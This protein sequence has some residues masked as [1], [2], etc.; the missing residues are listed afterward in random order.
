MTALRIRRASVNCSAIAASTSTVPLGA[1][2]RRAASRYQRRPSSSR[3]SNVGQIPWPRSRV[4]EARRTE[5]GGLGERT[6]ERGAGRVVGEHA[7]EEERQVPEAAEDTGSLGRRD[8][9]EHPRQ[10]HRVEL[11]EPAPAPT[12]TCRHPGAPAH[13]VGVR[14]Q[15]LDEEEAPQ[16]IAEQAP[17]RFDVEH[18]HSPPG[19]NPLVD[20]RRRRQPL[21]RAVHG[22][23]EG[24]ER[25]GDT[26]GVEARI[27]D[28]HDVLERGR[29]EGGGERLATGGGAQHVQ[30][31]GAQV[32]PIGA[33]DIR[34]HR[35][36]DAIPTPAA[37]RLSARRP[38]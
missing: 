8:G 4:L 12:P 30:I 23:G 10:L 25:R 37:P 27:V 2:E 29:R 17:Q 13:H 9:F 14:G 36:T 31:R 20:V 28:E 18:R 3:S 19:G 34:R 22:D 15:Q 1:G 24:E 38:P 6:P 26:G 16:R 11:A 32:L 7:G 35:D 5:Q 33:L 21:G